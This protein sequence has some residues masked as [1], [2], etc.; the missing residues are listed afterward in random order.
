MLKKKMLGG[1]CECNTF[2]KLKVALSKMSDEQLDYKLKYED[3]Y[4]QLMTLCL[5]VADSDLEFEGME[6]DPDLQLHEDMPVFQV[7]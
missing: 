5:T 2:R 7:G 6:F 4:N 1:L 3:N